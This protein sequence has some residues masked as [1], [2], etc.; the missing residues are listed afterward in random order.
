MLNFSD[1]LQ[2]IGVMAS[3]TRTAVSEALYSLVLALGSS[4]RPDGSAA[5]D[6]GV[7]AGRK[8][9]QTLIEQFQSLLRPKRFV[10]GV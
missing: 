9:Y 4:P 6:H 8:R 3:G 2:G 10:A 7:R 1:N 5:A